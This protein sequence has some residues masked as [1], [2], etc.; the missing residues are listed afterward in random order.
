MGREK[1]V[2]RNEGLKEKKNAVNSNNINENN[3]D[4]SR[5]RLTDFL[6]SDIV[7]IEK[8]IICFFRAGCNSRPVVTVHE[9]L[10]TEPV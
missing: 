1:N 10:R 5:K 3:Y 9:F 7:N 2:N 8:K 4:L 6:G